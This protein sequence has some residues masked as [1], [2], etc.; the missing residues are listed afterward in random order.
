MRGAG[1]HSCG[2]TGWLEEE[3]ENGQEEKEEKGEE[4]KEKEAGECSTDQDF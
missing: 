1:L 2:L 3:G 4:V